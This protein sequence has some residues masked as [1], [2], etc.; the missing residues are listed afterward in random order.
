MG[1]S[2]CHHNNN[3]NNHNRH[4]FFIALTGARAKTGNCTRRDEI[5][6]HKGADC[7]L[8][9][10]FWRL[11]LTLRLRLRLGLRLGL[12]TTTRSVR[13]SMNRT[14]PNCSLI[15]AE[16]TR[17]GR[18]RASK[19]RLSMHS[20]CAKL[21]PSKQRAA[22]SEVERI[23]PNQTELS[24]A[25]RSRVALAHFV[26]GGQFYSLYMGRIRHA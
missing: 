13:A 10:V 7:G 3:S 2:S 16:L 17:P 23:E 1:F 14:E 6:P 5:G 22:S 4:E 26:S 19:A 24:R 15:N 18:Q 21:A 12:G 25:E 8:R 9:E 20:R 11:R